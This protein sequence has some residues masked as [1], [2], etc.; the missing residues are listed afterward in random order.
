MKKENK[1]EDNNKSKP[2][3]PKEYE[4]LILDYVK[5]FPSGLTIA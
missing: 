1:I 5:Q 2:L 3:Q 4:K